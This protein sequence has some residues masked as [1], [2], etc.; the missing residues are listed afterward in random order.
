MHVLFR[1]LSKST[2]INDPANGRQGNE[3][4]HYLREGWEEGGREREGESDGNKD[5]RRGRE[6]GPVCNY[7][8]QMIIHKICY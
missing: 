1:G 3:W 4:Q 5:G 6:R 8:E 2:H 7:R